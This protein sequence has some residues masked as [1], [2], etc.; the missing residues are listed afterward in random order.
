MV[1][2]DVDDTYGVYSL[3]IGN[4]TYGGISASDI[5]RIRDLRASGASEVFFTFRGASFHATVLPHE[6]VTWRRQ[7]L[8][9]VIS[10]PE[11]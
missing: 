9:P 11:G 5:V 8:P 10:S 2:M 7:G 6:T 3:T 1:L 4:Q